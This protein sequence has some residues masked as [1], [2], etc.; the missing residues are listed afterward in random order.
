L[1]PPEV[2]EFCRELDAEGIL[3]RQGITRGECEN[4]FKGPSNANSS[5]VIAA[6]CGSEGT[7]GYVGRIFGVTVTNKGQ[8]IKLV[9]QLFSVV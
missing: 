1:T 4:L 7:R 2:A 9:R 8:C 6:V 5:N 3:D